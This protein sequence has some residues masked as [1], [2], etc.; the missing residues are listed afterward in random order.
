[1][2]RTPIRNRTASDRTEE[3]LLLPSVSPR[4]QRTL[5]GTTEAQKQVVSALS[6]LGPLIGSL[7]CILAAPQLECDAMRSL[8][9]ASLLRGDCLFGEDVRKRLTSAHSILVPFVGDSPDEV[10]GVLSEL[11]QVQGVAPIMVVH[12]VPKSEERDL[13]NACFLIGLQ[14]EKARSELLQ[15]G[16]DDV[17]CMFAG[18]VLR[19]HRV[20]EFVQRADFMARRLNELVEARVAESQKQADL[21]LQQKI[22]RFTNSLP[23]TAAP[24]ETTDK[25]GNL[26]SIGDYKLQLKIGTGGFGAVYKCHHQKHGN[27]AVKLISKRRALLNPS[28]ALALEQEFNILL[29]L[30][31][32][33]NLVKAHQVLHGEQYIT[34]IMNYAG[35]LNL[36]G[37]WQANFEF[38]HSPTLP[39]KTIRSFCKQQAAAVLH[40]HSNL[41]CH[42]DL[43]PDNW[44]V[45]DQGEVVRL[46]DFGLAVHLYST[47]QLVKHCCGTLPYT[48]PEVWDSDKDG[49]GY[50][51]LAADVWS[52]GVGYLEMLEGLKG[53]ER[54]LG[55][56][57]GRPTKHAEVLRSLKSLDLH[58]V[59]VAENSR[60]RAVGALVKKI[61]L[62]DPPQR[63]PIRRIHNVQGVSWIMRVCG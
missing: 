56:R 31:D 8:G 6:G 24:F 55:W 63:L 23:G 39:D 27:C 61:V 9:F 5:S 34:V 21:N 60:L 35:R 29:H 46:T 58:A 52:L 36:L 14:H 33:E 49:G 43:K 19:A 26:T 40:L 42:R 2:A 18:E 45:D 51:G 20:Q 50:D 10:F 7:C 4:L 48:A 47:R 41:V 15:A 1:M 62:V 59:A 28:E 32:H 37:F 11:A 12:I 57:G 16:A 30:A 13:A 44:I 3:P 53:L 22:K 54:L 17:T 25:N 38:T